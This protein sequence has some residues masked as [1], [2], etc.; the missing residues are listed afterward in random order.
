MTPVAAADKRTLIRRATLDLT[1]LPPTIEEIEAFEKDTSAD[2]FAKVIDRLLD[3]AAATAKPGDVSGS[4]SRA[5]PKTIRAASTRWA[6]GSRRT[7]T[8]IS[9][10]TG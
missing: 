7:R 4:T 6:A 8:P 2:A 9:I 5:T 10:A 1:G 3:V